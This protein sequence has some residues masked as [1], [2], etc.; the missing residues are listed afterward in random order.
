MNVFSEYFD[1]NSDAKF[2][3]NECF[4]EINDEIFDK[5][6]D[7]IFDKKFDKNIE[8]EKVKNKINKVFDCDANFELWNKKIIDSENVKKI[9]FDFF[10]W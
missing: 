8:I 4:D 6:F 2:E 10:A 9:N 3:K 5:I 7:E 1:T